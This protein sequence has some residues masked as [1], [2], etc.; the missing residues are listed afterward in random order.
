[1]GAG[2]YINYS[3]VYSVVAAGHTAGVQV[4]QDIIY[5]MEFLLAI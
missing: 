3:G 2:Q 1:M 4:G 5:A